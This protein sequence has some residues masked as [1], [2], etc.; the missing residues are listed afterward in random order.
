MFGTWVG[1][2]HWLAVIVVLAFV[3]VSAL[4]VDISVV[5]I[6]VVDISVVAT[7]VEATGSAQVGLTSSLSRT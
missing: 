4:V 5:V 1:Y 2:R 3:V 6:V 7:V